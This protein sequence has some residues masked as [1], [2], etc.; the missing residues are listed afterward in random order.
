[1]DVVFLARRSAALALAAA[2]TAAAVPPAALGEEVSAAAVPPAPGR[3]IVVFERGT[4]A[5]ARAAVRA[6]AD[7]SA[8]K[9]LGRADFQLVKPDP[10]QTVGDAVG[11]LRADPAVRSAEPDGF[12]HIQSLPNDPKLGQLWGLRNLAQNVG[13]ATGGVAGADISAVRAWDRTVGTP[14]T[15]VADLDTGYRFQHPDLAPVAWANPGEIPGNGVDDDSNGYMDDTRGWDAAT[16]DNDPT[17]PAQGHG[18]HTAGTIGARGN[19][20]IGVSGVAQ[21]VRI[22]P[23]RVCND[24]GTCPYSAQVEGINYAG[25]NGARAANMSLGGTS[26]SLAVLEALGSNPGSLF[27]ISAGNDGQDNDPGGVPHFPCSF[28][29]ASADPGLGYAPPAGAV[30][31][32]LCVAATTQADGLAGFSDYGLA[33]VDLGAPGTETL[34][35]DI[36]TRPYQEDFEGSGFGSWSVAAPATDGGFVRSPA[37]PQTSFGLTNHSSTQAAG[38]VRGSTTPAFSPPAGVTSCTLSQRRTLALAG[39]DVYSYR[40]LVD[41]VD[42]GG[43]S[44]SASGTFTFAFALADSPAPHSVK[45]QFTYARAAASPDTSGAWLDDLKVTCAVPPGSEDGESYGFKSGTSMAAPHVTGAAALL[46]SLRP[47]ASVAEVKQALLAGVDRADA[48]D[49][50]TS[51]G[52]RLNAFKA[53]NALV[54]LDTAIVSGPPA[55]TTAASATFAFDTAGTGTA[56]FECRLDVADFAAC[57]SPARVTGLGTG[58]HAFEVRSTV[59]GVLDATPAAAHWTV[60]EPAEAPGSPGPSPPGQGS[61]GTPGGPGGGAA[62]KGPA[63]TGLSLSPV[64]FAVSS[65]GAPERAVA[66][67]APKGTTFRFTSATAARV[68]YTVEA[69]RPGRRSAGRCAAPTRANRGKA[70]CARAVFAG[71]FAAPAAAGANRKSFSGR[72]GAARLTPGSYRA[73]LAAVS[74]GRR[75]AARSVAFAVAAR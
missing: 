62:A 64:R 44:P 5:P 13:G 22:M 3:V 39:G 17:D 34:S 14:G 52:G 36:T 24:G 28:D 70:R 72:I 55:S 51:T 26:A 37:A 40:V 38:S 2:S 60:A 21:N 74:G 68:V 9:M 73:T 48:L 41:D 49:G 25:R 42:A 35:A 32:V 53:L 63:I 47:S 6:D 30:D 8:I 10:G 61:A 1:M 65:R 45:V 75:S 69:L 46:F 59:A 56:S 31:N 20:G 27:V 33:S 54:P 43:S 58:P 71:R 29:P 57:T 23:V 19:D 66:A 12:S 15:V 7:T 4:T 11:A 18:V 16:G 67:V 50:K